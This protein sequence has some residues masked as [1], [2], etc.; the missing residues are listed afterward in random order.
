MIR[1]TFAHRSIS[2]ECGVRLFLLACV[3]PD[4][5]VEEAKTASHFCSITPVLR[6][7]G[8][9]DRNNMSYRSFASILD[10]HRG[11]I[12]SSLP[13]LFSSA[14]FIRAAEDYC[15]DDYTN[16]LRARNYRVLHV[17]IA[18]W[19][20]APRYEKVGEKEIIDKMGNKCPNKLWRKYK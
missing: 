18:R 4:R 8:I 11:K 7:S 2:A 1:C 10:A 9:K 12:E 6:P 19:Y 14:Q 13:T 3:C 16:M 5:S 15:G 17:W 20:L